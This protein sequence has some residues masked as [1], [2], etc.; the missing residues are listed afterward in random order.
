M[1]RIELN[2]LDTSWDEYITA[3]THTAFSARLGSEKVKVWN[4]EP[5]TLADQPD[6]AQHRLT[7]THFCGRDSELLNASLGKDGY[8]KFL[9]INYSIFPQSGV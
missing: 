7:S 3:L 9:L 2:K 5:P 4:A 6:E 1:K 8:F